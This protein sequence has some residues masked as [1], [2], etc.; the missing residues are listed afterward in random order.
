MISGYDL[1][2]CENTSEYDVKHESGSIM[3]LPLSC[4]VLPTGTAG[5]IVG[6]KGAPQHNG[7]AGLL[8]ETDEAADRYVVAL[9]RQSSLRLKRANFRA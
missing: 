4:V 6:L 5:V 8:I 1:L 7:K 3:R 2:S 9:D